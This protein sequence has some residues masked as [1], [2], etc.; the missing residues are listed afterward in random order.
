MICTTLVL[1]EAEATK[2]TIVPGEVRIGGTKAQRAECARA[3][4]CVPP[5]E[6]LEG[7]VSTSEQRVAGPHAE[8]PPQDAQADLLRVRTLGSDPIYG[9]SR[10]AVQ[11]AQRA[12]VVGG[13]SAQWFSAGTKKPLL[14]S[15]Q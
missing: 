4:D 11:A 13:A 10:L 2:R 8:T 9:A 15:L 6:A 1:A 14:G 5:S 7:N 12:L 3:G